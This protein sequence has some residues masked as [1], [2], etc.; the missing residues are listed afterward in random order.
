MRIDR[1][2]FRDPVDVLTHA[3]AHLISSRGEAKAKA[4]LAYEIIDQQREKFTNL[5]IDSLISPTAREN[6]LKC[7]CSR[8]IEYWE[9]E[10]WTVPREDGT[11]NTGDAAW[12][13]GHGTRDTGTAP[14]L[15][16]GRAAASGERDDD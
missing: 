14:P 12:D 4:S 11:R 3:L 10:G 5:C 13:R 6:G 7:P 15:R 2:N 8:H 9:T 16:D 1:E